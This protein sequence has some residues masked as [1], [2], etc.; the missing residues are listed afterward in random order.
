MSD[1]VDMMVDLLG[2]E[3]AEAAYQV[4]KTKGTHAR[5]G[6]LRKILRSVYRRHLMLRKR[7]MWKTCR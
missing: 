4:R 7:V 6:W 5:F 2:S 3:P 1:A